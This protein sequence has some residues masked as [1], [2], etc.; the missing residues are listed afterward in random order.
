[1]GVPASE[2]GYTSAT[3]GRGDHEVYKGHVVALE[4]KK[5]NNN[6]SSP[7]QYTT[8]GLLHEFMPGRKCFCPTVGIPCDKV[9]TSLASGLM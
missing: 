5:N 4:K 8:E 2:V 3:T 6:A 7:L 1:M 9:I